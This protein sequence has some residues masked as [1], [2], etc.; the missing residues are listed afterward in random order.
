VAEILAADPRRSP[1]EVMG[2]ALHVSD[3]VMQD[4]IA[5]LRDA[6][7]ITPG[8]AVE[9]TDA[10]TRAAALARAAADMGVEVETGER[11]LE[12]HGELVASALRSVARRLLESW[13]ALPGSDYAVL[14]IWLVSAVPAALR[15]F[16]LPAAPKPWTPRRPVWPDRQLESS[17]T[18][19]ARH[20]VEVSE[21]LEGSERARE[22]RR[23]VRTGPG[24]SVSERGGGRSSPAGSGLSWREQVDAARKVAGAEHDERVLRD[25][26]SFRVTRDDRT[27]QWASAPAFKSDQDAILACAWVVE[28]AVATSHLLVEFADRFGLLAAPA[29]SPT[30]EQ[31]P[32]D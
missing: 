10:A 3:L 12:E 30:D 5:A 27:V 11:A 31:E 9:L 28:M 20:A 22:S 1:R 13:S 16:E 17:A 7:S 29:E 2:D 15:G 6:E 26:A 24:P 4:K 21:V 19:A 18:V 14:E 23:G 8:A 25:R 32:P